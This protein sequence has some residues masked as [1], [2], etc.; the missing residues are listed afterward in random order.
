ML[1]T[2]FGRSSAHR[3]AMLA[4]LVCCL[5]EEKRIETTLSRAKAAGSLAEKMVTLARRG[6]LA[7][8][9]SAIATLRRTSTVKTLFEQIAPQC[10]DR[11]GGYTRIIKCGARRGDNAPMA[12]LEWVSIAPVDKKKKKPESKT[13]EKKPA[14]T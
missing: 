2:T 8:R 12:I 6:S 1:S 14:S 5:I 4:R 9:R 11:S 10:Q 13:D 7:A 3:R